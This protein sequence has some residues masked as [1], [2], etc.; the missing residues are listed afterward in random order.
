M[1]VAQFIKDEVV[2]IGVVG[3]DCSRI[4]DIVDEIV[5]G[6]GFN[7]SHFILTSS[8]EGK[9]LEEAIEFA[10]SLAGEYAGEVQV[11]QI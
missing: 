6:E 7:N 5:V 11:V 2:F 1:M 9:S 8:H 3:K 4:E 10:E